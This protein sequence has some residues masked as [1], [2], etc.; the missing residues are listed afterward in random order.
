MPPTED[1]QQ[2][3]AFAL[4]KYPERVEMIPLDQLLLESA[5]QNDKRAAYV[6]LA[7]VDD[8]VKSLKGRESERDLL[9]L[10][11]IPREVLAR[12]ES[13]IILPGEVR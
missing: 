11:R 7:V 10:V 5:R 13:R 4:E 2:A 9:L 8:L 3:L 12:R 1:P 6:K